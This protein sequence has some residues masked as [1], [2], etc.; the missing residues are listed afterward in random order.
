M[1][2]LLEDFS[3]SQ[4][5][6]FRQLHDIGSEHQRAEKATK[7]NAIILPDSDSVEHHGSPYEQYVAPEVTT[8]ATRMIIS[9][10]LVVAANETLQRDPD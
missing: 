6:T 1:A 10:A 3:E 9:P 5:D 8:A 2:Q 4:D 7:S